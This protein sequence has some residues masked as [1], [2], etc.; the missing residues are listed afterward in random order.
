MY[1]WDLDRGQII[2]GHRGHHLGVGRTR[3]Q[4]HHHHQRH[5][6][7]TPARGALCYLNGQRVLSS[8]DSLF[9][10]FSVASN[11]FRTIKI[12]QLFDRD[13]VVLMKGS[14]YDENIVACGSKRGLVTIINIDQKSIVHKFSAHSQPITSLAWQQMTF[15]GPSEPLLVVPAAAIA[16]SAPPSSERPIAQAHHS[17]EARLRGPPKTIVDADDA[18]DIYDFDDGADEFGVISRATYAATTTVPVD[19][20]NKPEQIAANADFN[21]VEACESL[22]DDMLRAVPAAMD[23]SCAVANDFEKLS[24]SGGSDI[25]IAPEDATLTQQAIDAAT[26]SAKLS[27]TDHS[28]DESFVHVEGGAE[29]VRR[30]ITFIASASGGKESTIWLWNVDA[31]GSTHKI[32]LKAAA[33]SHKGNKIFVVYIYI[34]MCSFW[35]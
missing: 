3:A 35:V 22:V 31:G 10:L 2:K 34:Y 1:I 25:V 16:Q 32:Q 33:K 8:I 28:S 15:S 9:V 13:P 19:K 14:P 24:L 5:N 26:A 11:T 17:K 7:N 30:T 23:D 27:E 18:F 6:S 12:N 4:Q 21:F 29:A 20:N